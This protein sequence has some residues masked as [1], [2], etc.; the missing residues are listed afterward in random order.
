VK[1]KILLSCTALVLLAIRFWFP[2]LPVDGTAPRSIPGTIP[3]PIVRPSPSEAALI[4]TMQ[5]HPGQG[6]PT[7]IVHGTLMEVA[8]A[9]A[10]DMAE[11]GYFDHI[12]PDGINANGRVID[13]GYPLPY[14]YDANSIESIAAGHQT[15]QE[16]WDAWMGSPPHRAHLLAED[17]FFVDQV[18]VGVGHVF[19]EGSEYGH[20]WVVVTAPV[21]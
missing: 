16:A 13:A 9:H 2:W 5:D 1:P 14:A 10:A 4:L 15:V 6:R 3:P 21:K 18:Y 19:V 17:D 20:Y 11:R 12:N 7:L 8:E